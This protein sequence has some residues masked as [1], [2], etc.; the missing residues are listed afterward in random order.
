MGN[1]SSSEEEASPRGA[2]A[3]GGAACCASPPPPPRQKAMPALKIEG[4]KDSEGAPRSALLSSAEVEELNR[5]VGAASEWSLLF[6][7]ARHGKSY[8][9][10]VNSCIMR[11]RS[12]VV[13]REEGPGG[14]VFG[15]HADCSWKEG[16][17]F[18][19]GSKCFMFHVERPGGAGAGTPARTGGA[20]DAAV[21]VGARGAADTTG[22]GNL[23][24]FDTTG[25]GKVDAKD[26]SGDGLID[27]IDTTGDGK[28]DA[29]DA[30]AGATK[31]ALHRSKGRDAN[32]LYLNQGSDNNPNCLA[33]GGDLYNFSGDGKSFTGVFGLSI[34]PSM[35]H[36]TCAE[37]TTYGNPVFPA[38]LKASDRSFAIDE[39]EI[40]GTEPDFELSVDEKY[41]LARKMGTHY[42]AATDFVM[43]SA[44]IAQNA[45]DAGIEDH[46]PGQ[47]D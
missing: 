45:K 35:N 32:H 33:F 13:V 23:D 43:Q 19:G 24:S 9:R 28:M 3:K 10:M 42:D 7:S 34:E 47:G 41:E 44:G 39:L 15:G 26:T 36:G 30:A 16:A 14:R 22:D 37:V 17:N 29:F 8:A 5:K 20:G 1:A 46:K 40:W 18:F 27:A 6:S 4:W 11:G 38:A 31:V 2:K 12:L 25:D 21:G